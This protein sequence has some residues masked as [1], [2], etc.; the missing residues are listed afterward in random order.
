M[1]NIIC[2]IETIKEF[3]KRKQPNLKNWLKSFTNKKYK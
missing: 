2:H 1:T 3:A